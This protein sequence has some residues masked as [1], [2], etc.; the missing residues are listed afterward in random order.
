MKKP[1]TLFVGLDVHKDSIS[2]A[3][4]GDDRRAE[5]DYVGRIGTK[6]ADIDRLMRRL[7]DK[8]ERVV[9]A[10]EAGPTGYGLHR[11]LTRRGIAC[12][13][14][15]G[16]L[17]SPHAGRLFSPPLHV[18]RAAPGGVHAGSEEFA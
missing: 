7:E 3:H 8:A 17:L 18:R 14:S 4:V 2:V 6:P 15:L 9:V 1:T 16:R 12:L 13:V 5:V 10:Y 11:Q